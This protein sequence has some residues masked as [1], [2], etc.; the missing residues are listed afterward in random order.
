MAE[1]RGEAGK[2]KERGPG[3]QTST[4]VIRKETKE[5]SASAADCSGNWC[6]EEVGKTMEKCGSNYSVAAINER[7]DGGADRGKARGEGQMGVGPVMDCVQTMKNGSRKNKK[8]T[9]RCSLGGGA[10]SRKKGGIP[11]NN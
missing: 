3:T 7:A 10:K 9:W 8:K 5:E 4:G 11:Q 6:Q 2:D 1:G